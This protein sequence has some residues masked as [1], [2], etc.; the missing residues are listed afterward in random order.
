[1]EIKSSWSLRIKRKDTWVLIPIALIVL[2]VFIIYI[3]YHIN[4]EKTNIPTGLIQKSSGGNSLRMALEGNANLLA[5]DC[6]TFP[7]GIQ[8]CCDDPAYPVVCDED[9]CG[10]SQAWCDNRASGGNHCKQSDPNWCCY[11]SGAVV[12]ND[13][14]DLC[15][16]PQFCENYNNG[17]KSCNEDKSLCCNDAGYIFA[18]GTNYCCPPTS[19]FLNTQT[20]LCYTTPQPGSDNWFTR[21]S[22][23]TSGQ[24]KCDGY[25]YSECTANNFLYQYQA[26]GLVKGKC[27]VQC[28]YDQDCSPRQNSSGLTCNGKD[29]VQPYTIG[30]CTSSMCATD[31]I[32]DTIKTC[33]Y[34]CSDGACQ[35]NVWIYVL[36]IGLVII[37]ILALVFFIWRFYFHKKK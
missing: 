24:T 26:K 23:C 2:V 30:R 14:A 20:V 19:P 21:N 27:E 4:V 29:I 25:I 8:S 36:I 5:G 6:R 12:C 9:T 31:N 37:S 17:D 22:E 18:Y 1:M 10:P 13:N 16:T 33:D 11:E 35:S 28:L 34:K 15:G 3:S 7:D 32:N